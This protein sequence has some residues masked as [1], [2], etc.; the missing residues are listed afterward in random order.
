MSAL[1]RWLLGLDIIVTLAANVAHVLSHG[2]VV[3]AWPAVALV[4]LYE[5][6]MMIFRGAQTSTATPPPHERVSAA[7]P[8]GEQAAAVFA[9]ELAVVRIPSVRAVCAALHVGQPR[10]QRLREYLAAVASTA[11]SSQAHIGRESITILPE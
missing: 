6:L 5:L 8:L 9:V 4:G 3:A 7:D 10:A 1:A 11:T 2:I